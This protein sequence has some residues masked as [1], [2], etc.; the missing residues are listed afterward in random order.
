[1]FFSVLVILLVYVP[2][3]S[4]TGVD[5]KLF[6]PMVLMVVFALTAALL[7]SVTWVPAMASL[8]LRVKDI[9]EHGGVHHRVGR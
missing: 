1:M 6:R 2:V 4:L 8:V 3:L 5:G 7:L 9:P